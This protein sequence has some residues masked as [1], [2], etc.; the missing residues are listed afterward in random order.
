MKFC[1]IFIDFFQIFQIQGLP[2]ELYTLWHQYPWQLGSVMCSLKTLILE[3][4]ANASV[5]TLGKYLVIFS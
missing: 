4:T 2:L 5:L 3:G 1:L